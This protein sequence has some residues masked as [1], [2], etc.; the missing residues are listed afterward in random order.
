MILAIPD[1]AAN[2]LVALYDGSLGEEP[3]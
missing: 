2:K 3:I 1:S